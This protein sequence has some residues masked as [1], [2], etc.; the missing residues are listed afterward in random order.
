MIDRR[1]LLLGLLLG[2]L[3]CQPVSAL[4]QPPA[5]MLA[6]FYRGQGD[7]HDYWVS[8]KLDGVRGY[9]TGTR[10]LS[11]GGLEIQAP[12]W[13][14]QDWPATP[15]DGELWI[16]RGRFAEVSGI[17]RTQTPDDDAWR[18]VR[19]MVFDLPTQ[20]GDFDTRLQVM[21]TLI[22]GR[23]LPQ[24]TL[25]QQ[26]RVDDAA[27]LD[28]QLDTIVAKGG[29]GLMLH[30]ADAP[31]RAMRSDDLLKLKPYEDAEARV[32]GYQAGRGKYQ[33]MLGA[34]VVETTD[35]RRFELGTG[36]SDAE[37]RDP[38]AL[39]HWVTYR[40]NGLTTHGLPRFARYLRVREDLPPPDPDPEAVRQ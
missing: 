38:P 34:L 27:A 10:L 13:F 15:M 40:Y 35:G 4:S 36:F 2:G 11:R 7:V 3:G 6:E 30:R 14:T 32:V 31:Y 21:R 26:W 8:E 5:L 1:T 16:G 19:F 9:W 28:A 39:G 29:E 17:V 25:I 12:A 23:N 37:R 33:G 20:P 22:P 24:L 18:N